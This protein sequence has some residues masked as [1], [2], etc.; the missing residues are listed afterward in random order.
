MTVHCI[1]CDICC[2]DD[3]CQY[4]PHNEI[5]DAKTEADEICVSQL[6]NFISK[7][8]SPFNTEN[9]GIQQLATGTQLDKKGSQFLL[10]VIPIDESAVS[11]NVDFRKNLCNFL[12]G[13]LRTSM[14]DIDQKE[15]NIL[16]KQRL[17]TLAMQDF[18]AI[19][20]QTYQKMK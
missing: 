8:G 10:N 14:K 4:S 11:K 19:E 3:Q 6:Q 18:V 15:K 13:I 12:K 16:R 2:L 9:Q 17:S 7:W 5:S 20:L 1:L